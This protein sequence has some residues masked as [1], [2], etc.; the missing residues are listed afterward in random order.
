M[1]P[2]T[3]GDVLWSVRPSQWANALHF[4]IAA[5][6]ILMAGP[7]FVITQMVLTQFG[8]DAGSDSG[9]VAFFAALA[10]VTAGLLYMSWRYLVIGCMSYTVTTHQLQ[11]YRGVLD[12]V[13]D[14]LELYRVKDVQVIKPFLLRRVGLGHI[15]LDSSDRSTPRA[16]LLAIKQ[17]DEIGRLILTQVEAMRV[18][19]GVREFD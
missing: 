19:K 5:L 3:G 2:K 4:V 11:A 14:S 8:N 18:I 10:F 17:P 12:Q 1:T 9:W 16:V 7:A 6:V 13:I 15:L